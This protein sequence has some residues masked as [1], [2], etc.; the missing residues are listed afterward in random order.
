VNRLILPVLAVALAAGETPPPPSF[1]PVH[2][3]SEIRKL[4]QA[5]LRPGTDCVAEGVLLRYAEADFRCESLRYRMADADGGLHVLERADL[6][7]G[8]DG[9][10]LCDSSRTQLPRLGFRGL[11]R[12]STATITRQDA[13]PRRN[14]HRVE[15]GDVRDFHGLVATA[16]GDRPIVAWA[17][18]LVAELVSDQAPNGDGG[19]ANPR[20]AAMHLYARPAAEGRP[21]RPATVLLIKG[22][23]LPPPPIEAAAVEAGDLV[24]GFV[25]GSLISLSFDDRGEV[26]ITGEDLVWG[27]SFQELLSLG[28]GRST[29][30]ILPG[31]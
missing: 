3:Y 23:T 19:M 10:L 1:Q 29:P 31:K 21:A 20:L 6:A 4:V 13:E 26:G 16:K 2:L 22:A 12:G 18:H 17:D 28:K 30:A 7:G 11:L 27:G 14:R 5:G 9:R 8:P 24:E 25:R 15:I